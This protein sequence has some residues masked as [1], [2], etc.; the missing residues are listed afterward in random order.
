MILRNELLSTNT[1]VQHTHIYTVIFSEIYVYF[2]KWRPH[3]KAKTSECISFC[4]SITSKAFIDRIIT[5]GIWNKM[6]STLEPQRG[7]RTAKL[8]AMRCNCVA[9][10]QCICSLCDYYLC[11]RLNCLYN[12]V[13]LFSSISLLA[14]TMWFGAYTNPEWISVSGRRSGSRPCLEMIIL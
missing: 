11:V 3:P 4:H 14:W 5:H 6:H 8:V 1:L 13:Y 12:D 2:Q 10:R 7:M 9:N